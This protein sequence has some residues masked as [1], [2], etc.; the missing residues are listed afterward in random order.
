MYL[1]NQCWNQRLHAMSMFCEIWM[2]NVTAS[3]GAQMDE[4][5]LKNPGWKNN[6][7]TNFALLCKTNKVNIPCAT[8]HMQYKKHTHKP[9]NKKKTQH[10]L[11]SQRPNAPK[12]NTKQWLSRLA[13]GL[14]SRWF[15]GFV[16]VA[17]LAQ[18]KFINPRLIFQQSAVVLWKLKQTVCQSAGSQGYIPGAVNKLLGLDQKEEKKTWKNVRVGQGWEHM[19]P[20]VTWHQNGNPHN[21]YS[22]SSFGTL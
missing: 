13:A 2:F 6:M 7:I 8:T 14:E 4:L 15:C 16:Y 22:D 10:L 11:K 9:E 5:K 21:K 17:P 18:S 12:T 19:R 3:M 20:H 1:T